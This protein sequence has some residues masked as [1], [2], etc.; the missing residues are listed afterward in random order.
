VKFSHSF[1]YSATV[2]FC[3]I[4]LF[5]L[6]DYYLILVHSHDDGRRTAEDTDAEEDPDHRRLS[7]VEHCPRPGDQRK[8]DGMLR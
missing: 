7:V 1:I 2:T 8:G 4:G 3:L 5:S 6:P